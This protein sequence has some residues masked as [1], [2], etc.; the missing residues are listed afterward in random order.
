MVAIVISAIIYI[1]ILKKIL[2]YNMCCCIIHIV[3]QYNNT[4]RGNLKQLGGNHLKRQTIGCYRT[5][6][7]IVTKHCIGKGEAVWAVN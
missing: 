3:Q 5:L 4:T 2:P 6:H 1:K 7:R